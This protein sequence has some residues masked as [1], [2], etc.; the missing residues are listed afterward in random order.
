[1]RVFVLTGAGLSAESGIATFSDAPDALWARYDP[2]RLAT[3][4]AFAADPALVH[5]FYSHRRARV[6][7]ASPNAAHRA[8][9]RLQA[10]LRHRG[11]D[12]V[13]CTQNVDD[14]LERGGAGAVMHMHGSLLEGRCMRCAAVS[15]WSEPMDAA[16]LC[17]ACGAAG[18]MR[19]NVVWFGE[20]PL[21]LDE[22]AAGIRASD[23][24]VAIG[25]SGTVYPAAGFV[26]LARNAGVPTAEI[27]LVPSDRAGAFDAVRLGPATEMV[28][29][30]VADVLEHGADPA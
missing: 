12:A 13:L 6:L 17:P 29:A 27:N 8:L 28:P 26:D 9:A 14:L 21:F 22:I 5:R 20:M 16:S 24:F 30:W 23:L 25:T 7:Q 15:P 2:M 4:E 19:P 1:M 3:P 10:G 11:G 18:R